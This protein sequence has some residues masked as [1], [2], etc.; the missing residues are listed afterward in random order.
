MI[1]KLMLALAFA[2]AMGGAQAAVLLVEDFDN[3]AALPGQGWIFNNASAP[4][5]VAPGWVQGNPAVFPAQGVPE[6]EQDDDIR[7]NYIA[8]SFE[9]AA[10]GGQLN[11]QLFTPLFSLENGAIATFWLRGAPEEEFSDIVIYGYTEG[12]TDPA[13]F[14]ESMTVTAPKDGWRMYTLTINPMAGISGRLGFVHAGPEASS[15]YVGLDTLR[16]NT[17]REPAG[18][19]EP[20]SLLIFGLGMAGLAAAR[21]RR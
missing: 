3:V 1:K 7:D 15:N 20:A 13:D 6:D 2:S 12:S 8:S 16:V 4:Q 21:R 17:L 10:P 5:G 11:D 9:S 19:P 14:I 18:V